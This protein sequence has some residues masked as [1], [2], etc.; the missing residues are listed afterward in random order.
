MTTVKKTKTYPTY[1]V[2]LKKTE[3]QL[4]FFCIETRK[5]AASFEGLNSSLG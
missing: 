1:D 5:F 4:S 2:T 3:T